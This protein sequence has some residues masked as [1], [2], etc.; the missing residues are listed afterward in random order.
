MSDNTDTLTAFG[1][2]DDLDLDLGPSMPRPTA[3]EIAEASGESAKPK[4]KRRA[5]EGASAKAKPKTP[6]KPKFEAR[7]A[8]LVNGLPVDYTPTRGGR[9]QVNMNMPPH[10]QA[11]LEDMKT[12]FDMSTWSYFYLGYMSW[13]TSEE[14]RAVLKEAKLPLRTPNGDVAISS[15]K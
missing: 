11:A 7:P 4:S 2:L 5:G 6:A 9:K 13:A 8:P 10:V 3:K 15:S 14:G 12:V 1:S